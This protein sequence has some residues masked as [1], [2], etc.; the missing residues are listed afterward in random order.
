MAEGVGGREET[1]VAEDPLLNLSGRCGA[2]EVVP[3]LPLPRL[4]QAG[5]PGQAPTVRENRMKTRDYIGQM[6]TRIPD[7]NNE[8]CF[9]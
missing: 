3:L 1:A 7:L 9:S 6:V 5:M 2:V 4:Y 8:L